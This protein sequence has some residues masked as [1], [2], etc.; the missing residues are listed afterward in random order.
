MERAGAGWFTRGEMQFT[1]KSGELD[2]LR[3]EIPLEWGDVKPTADDVAFEV[4]KLPGQPRRHLILRPRQAWKGPQTLELRGSLTTTDSGVR[5]PEVRVLDF[6]DWQRFVVLPTR[7]EK[8]RIQWALSG[9]ENVAWPKEVVPPLNQE[10]YRLVGSRYSA[11]VEDVEYDVGVPHVL[12]A[13][14]KVRVSERNSLAGDLAWELVPNGERSCVITVPEQL[15]VLQILV[16][17]S[18]A[19][20]QGVGDGKWR[21]TLASHDLPQR[22]SVEFSA[23][24]AG[25]SQQLL[26]LP[27]LLGLPVERTSW[28]ILGS[29]TAPG[30]V[31]GERG[32]AVEAVHVLTAALEAQASALK[33]AGGTELTNESPEFAADWFAARLANWQ[34]TKRNLS[35]YLER[36]R[37]TAELSTRIKAAEGMWD[38]AA[39]VFSSADEA[40]TAT[41]SSGSSLAPLRY[42]TL[43]SGWI[44]SQT[45]VLSP[46]VTATSFRGWWWGGLLCVCG[47]FGLWVLRQNW[48]AIPAELSPAVML[49][50]GGL[51]ALLSIQPTWL[52]VLLLAMATVWQVAQRKSSLRRGSAR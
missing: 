13:A 24:L 26:E 31:A 18:A 9:L 40:G 33:L 3:L 49:A 4:R 29:A 25:H 51:V 10:L 12:L 8:Q 48:F 35:Q 7:F 39:S 32:L 14:A 38:E 37:V 16:D 28:V 47:A 30:L 45:L 23:A 19:I 43:S 44:S 34:Q 5:V 42:A 21:V 22:V 27:A 2:E 50:V 6:D 1:V 20:V 41:G 11:A 46:P 36:G 15:R 52:G 17:G